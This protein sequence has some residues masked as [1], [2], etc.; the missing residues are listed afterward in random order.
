LIANETIKFITPRVSLMLSIGGQATGFN[1]Q[2]K[3]CDLN[4]FYKKNFPLDGQTRQVKLSSQPVNLHNA[5]LALN[6]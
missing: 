3:L 2:A 4:F 6:E 5:W 1:R